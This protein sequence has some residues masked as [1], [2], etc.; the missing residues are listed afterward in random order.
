MTVLGHPLR[1][2]D[3]TAERGASALRLQGRVDP[4]D[5][6]GHLL[7]IRVGGE[8]IKDAQLRHQMLAIVVGQ[9]V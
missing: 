1:A 6:A 4:Q 3:V 2:L 8:R 7:G 9:R 5:Q